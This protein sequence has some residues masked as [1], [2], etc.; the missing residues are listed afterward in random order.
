MRRSKYLA[1]ILVLTLI[2]SAGVSV[3][4]VAAQIPKEWTAPE[5][6]WDDGNYP[7]RFSISADG[8]CVVAL[9][10]YSGTDKYTRSIAVIHKVGGV[11]QAPQVIATNGR[12]SDDMVEWLPS[13]THPVISGDGQTIVYLGWSSDTDTNGA[14]VVTRQAGNSWSAPMY[15]TPDLANVHDKMS[16]SYDGTILALSDYPFFGTQHIYVLT[17]SGSAWSEPVQ[18]T[19]S[20]PEEFPGG[21]SP[22]LSPDGQHL[23][24]IYNARLM[25]LTRSGSDW[26]DPTPLTDNVWTE[27]EVEDPTFSPDSSTLYYWYTAVDSQ[28]TGKHLYLRRK[29]QSGWGAPEKVTAIPIVRTQSTEG[30]AASNYNAT[31]F[32]YPRPIIIDNTIYASD[33]ELLEYKDGTWQTMLLLENSN[34]F[35]MLNWPCLTPDS[36]TLVFSSS[37]RLSPSG[38]VT[39]GLWQMTTTPDLPSNTAPSF[40]S[41]PL[42]IAFAKS[43]YVY[44]VQTSDPD[45]GDSLMIT[46]T[47]L[48]AWLTLLSYGDGTAS[49]RGTPMLADM[50]SYEVSLI[51]T[52]K[53][54]LSDTQT[55]VI[56]VLGEAHQVFLPFV[57]W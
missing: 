39:G 53:D 27:Y 25:Y 17:R 51:V 45:I 23:T 54:G 47:S 50:G 21:N 10:P 9:L 34:G 30:P 56:V 44:S 15:I 35:D 26:S 49:L 18:V 1:L 28:N 29:T 13:F 19:P 57:G 2:S 55:F 7:A 33:L 5:V 48:P 4:S 37:Q 6:I 38:F 32:I 40:V 14:F 42:T 3:S 36:A 24:Y 11:W 22:S 16:L 43:E 52:D 46:S 31:R 12:F 41:V 8:S 20:S